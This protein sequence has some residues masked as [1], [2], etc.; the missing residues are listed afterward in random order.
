M[1]FR[2]QFFTR[3]SLQFTI[4]YNLRREVWKKGRS[5]ASLGVSSTGP[6]SSGRAA[7]LLPQRGTGGT[8]QE[9]LP[10]NMV[11]EGECL[12]EGGFPTLL[13]RASWSRNREVGQT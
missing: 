8:R 3:L 6:S 5:G 11:W 2:L 1:N 7:S 10:I 12:L 9:C 13:I 4:S